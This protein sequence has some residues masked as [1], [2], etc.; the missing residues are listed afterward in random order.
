MQMRHAILEHANETKWNL[1]KWKWDKIILEHAN[2][3]KWYLTK[4]KWDKIIF[5]IFWFCLFCL[6]HYYFV[7]FA[8]CYNWIMSHLHFILL[9]F[10]LICILL[11]VILFHFHFVI[12]ALVSRLNTKVPKYKKHKI[13]KKTYTIQ[14]TYKT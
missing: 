11:H 12:I 9:E 1:T 2:E 3:T 14:N 13:Q 7:P 5:V 6:L 10:C 4:W 8:L